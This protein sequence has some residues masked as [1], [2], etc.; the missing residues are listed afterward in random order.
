MAPEVS[1]TMCHPDVTS[2]IGNRAAAPPQ[3]PANTFGSVGNAAAGPLSISRYIPHPMGAANAGASATINTPDIEIGPTASATPTITAAHVA[4]SQT[5]IRR[6]HTIAD[7][8]STTT[9]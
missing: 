2:T 8:T 4:A 5:C 1:G 7:S 9:G 6:R 3:D